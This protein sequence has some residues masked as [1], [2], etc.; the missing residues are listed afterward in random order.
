MI[1]RRRQHIPDTP[2]LQRGSKFRIIAVHLVTGDGRR[3]HP[4]VQ[5]RNDHLQRQ[6]GFGRERP[7][8]AGTPARSRTGRVVGPGTFGR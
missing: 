4:G 8:S 7:Y 5:C 6:R 1:P 3:R 2:F